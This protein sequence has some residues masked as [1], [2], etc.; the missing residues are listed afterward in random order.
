MNAELTLAL[1]ILTGTFVLLWALEA[2]RVEQ[3]EDA[4]DH[5]LDLVDEL[6]RQVDQGT[7]NLAAFNAD[8]TR[9]RAVLGDEL[10]ELI[11][12]PSTVTAHSYLTRQ[13]KP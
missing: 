4:R 5:A 2:K 3:V 6:T 12:E 7:V 10:V 8:I 13:A 1:C 9:I 11:L